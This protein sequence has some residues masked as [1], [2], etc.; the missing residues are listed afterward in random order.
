M[1][2]RERQAMLNQRGTN[3]GGV[4]RNRDMGLDGENE[5]LSFFLLFC[6]VLF[7]S[8]LFLYSEKDEG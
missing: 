6:F 2:A 7:C 5:F 1:V 3:R 8:I 4:M